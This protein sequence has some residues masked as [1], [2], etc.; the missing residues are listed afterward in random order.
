MDT[1]QSLTSGDQ[2]SGHTGWS[3]G[4]HSSPKLALPGLRGQRFT[5]LRSSFI[6]RWRAEAQRGDV[7]CL[8]PRSRPR[9]E[10]RLLIRRVLAEH[11]LQV[12]ALVGPGSPAVSKA[13]G[14][15]VSMSPSGGRRWVHAPG[16]GHARFWQWCSGQVKPCGGGR[17]TGPL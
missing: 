1:V 14:P 16:S 6:C 12:G 2:A 7:T 13:G 9:S 11:L 4:C 10:L 5:E 3:C 8:G 17:V 15:A